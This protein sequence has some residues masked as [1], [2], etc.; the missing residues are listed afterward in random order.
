M[1][2]KDRDGVVE[3]LRDLEAAVYGPDE[4]GAAEISELERRA[5]RTLDALE[6]TGGETA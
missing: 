4:P 2:V 5:G 3:L 1:W 6:R